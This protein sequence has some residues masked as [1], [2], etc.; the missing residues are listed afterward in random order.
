MRHPLAALLLVVPALAAA[1]QGAGV[2][3]YNQ[4]LAAFNAGDYG[5]A[6]RSLYGLAEGA[7]DPEVK[8]KAQY[9]LA[10]AL[11]RKGL[12]TAAAIYETDIV[13]A[14][15][16]HPYY[17][18]AVEALADLQE[19]LKDPYL[20]PSV[21]DAQYQPSWKDLPAPVAGRV[22]YLVATS[23]ERGDKLEEAEQLLRSVP[24]ESSVYARARYLLG[25]IYSNPRFPNGPRNEDALKM[26]EEVVALPA[27][28]N[29]PE[30]EQ[31][32][33][34]ALLGVGRVYYG[35]GQYA[36]AVEAYERVPRFS[37]YW[38]QALFENGFARFRN[39]DYGGA[40]GSLQALHAPQFEGSF[41][42]ESWLLK[43]TV[44]HFSCLFSESKA[45]LKAFE[46]LYLPMAEKLKP[47]IDAQTDDYS[48]YEAMV[49]DPKSDKLPRPVLLW[50]RGNERIRG[51]FDLI[52]AIDR[53]KAALAEDPAW[54][55]TP[56]AT[57]LASYLDQNRQTLVQTAGKLVKNRLTEAY[58][59]I[60]KFNND[61]DLIRLETTLAEKR[62]LDQGVDQRKLL[63][64]QSLHRPAM[65]AENW[66]YWQFQGEFWIDEIGYYQYTLKRGCP[67]QA[68]GG[69]A[70][71]M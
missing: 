14:G 71:G 60:R 32:R 16:S 70:G 19:K 39:E 21:L 18:K 3:E 68:G 31:T 38:D 2:A 54:K 62:L 35:M 23:R 65:P 7:A 63:A 59:N 8:Q 47:L 45:S 36:K 55:G 15:P 6:A 4:G 58:Q 26:F 53:E 69:Q 49:A 12:L 56:M 44:Y 43:A 22:N 9:Y 34:L 5:T 29:D 51:V 25:V 66:N 20:I 30:S 17:L 48:G 11:A 37:R 64:D 57:E 41:Q 13:K 33:Q 46:D 40:L 61:G 1:Q 67:E 42:P 52:A 50:V 28:K 24:P 27:R 10:Q